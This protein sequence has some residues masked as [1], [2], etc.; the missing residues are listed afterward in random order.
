MIALSPFPRRLCKMMDTTRG[1]NVFS[2]ARDEEECYIAPAVYVDVEEGD[3]LLKDEIFGP[4]LP[5]LTVDN[6]EEA[7]KFTN[8]R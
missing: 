5:I 6:M 8:R 4:L 7:I 1:R 2:G 3:S